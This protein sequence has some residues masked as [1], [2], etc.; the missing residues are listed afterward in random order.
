MWE[1]MSRAGL[2]TQGFIWIINVMLAFHFFFKKMLFFL[3]TRL[4]KTHLTVNGHLRNRRQEFHLSN[5]NDIYIKQ[6][7]YLFI[8]FVSI[9]YCVDK[10]MYLCRATEYIFKENTNKKY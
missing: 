1:G 8:H 9:L 2:F 5:R 4:N 10:G 7:F 6:Y 3:L